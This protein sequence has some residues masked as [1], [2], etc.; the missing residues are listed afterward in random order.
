MRASGARDCFIGLDLGTSACKAVAI[1]PTGS[2]VARAGGQYTLSTPRFGWA[3]QDPA[4]WWR[5]VDGAMSAL[6][7]DLPAPDAVRA[8]GL[9]GQMHG[10]VAL[11]HA[12]RVIRPAMLWC[13]QRGVRQCEL[14]TERVGGLKAMLTLITN[15]LWPCDTAGKLLWLRDEEPAAYGRLRRFLLPKDYLRLRMTGEHATDV[16]D[17]SGTGMFD[18]AHRCWSSR[19][20][21]AVGLTPAQVPTASESQ[22]TT[23]RLRLEVAERW[24]LPPGVPVVGGGGDSVVQTTAMGI[25]SEGSLGVTLGTAGVVAGA[26]SACPD[27]QD[28]L[29]Q[30]SCGNAPDRWHTM[31][32]SLNGGGSLQWLLEILRE[33]P[34]AVLEFDALARLAEA[35]PAGSEGIVF[36]PHLMGE[37]CPYVAPGACGAVAG[38]ARTHRLGQLVRGAMEGVVLN[39]RGILEIFLRSGRRCDELRASG[40]ATTSPLWLSLL[41]DILG[42]EVVTVTGAS[43]GGAYGAALVAGVGAGAWRHLDEAVATIRETGRVRPDPAHG[44]R[45]ERALRVHRWTFRALQTSQAWPSAPARARGSG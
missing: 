16:S 35:A 34:G 24:G 44:Q 17:A 7:A 32:V 37:R 8:I 39:L 9:S 38:L 15:R 26:A 36:L 21:D 40:G 31:G 4:E 5:A 42:R 43:E 45:F 27:N 10:L 11:D 25:V 23:G 12:D 29:L 6:S 3:E 33:V 30:V 14:L 28:G 13:D 18:V 20:L 41:A 22:A 2:I 1:D 19:L